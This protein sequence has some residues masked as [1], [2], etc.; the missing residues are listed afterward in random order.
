VTPRR[1]DIVWLEFAPT[2]GH[3]QSGR[4]PAIVLSPTEYNEKVGLMLVSP[5]TSKSKNY[6]FEVILKGKVKGVILVDQIRSVDWRER[7]AQYIETAPDA[8]L[9]KTKQLLG[10]LLP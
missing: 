6:P 9:V 8:V 5:I 1:G 7:K 3:E 10:L 2:I 4:R